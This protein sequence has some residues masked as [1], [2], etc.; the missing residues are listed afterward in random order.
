M[1]VVGIRVLPGNG[2]RLKSPVEV[3]KGLKPGWFPFGN[4]SEPVLTE[5]G[6]CLQYEPLS[7]GIYD[8]KEGRLHITISAIVGKNGSGK[9][10]LLDYL[11]MLINNAASK[12]LFDQYAPDEQSPDYARG[13]FAELYYETEG[14][15]K[16]LRCIDTEVTIHDGWQEIA[17]EQLQYFIRYQVA[18]SLFYLVV[19]NYG[20]YSLNANDYEAKSKLSRFTSK[21]NGDW[22]NSAFNLEQ[23]YIFPIAITPYRQGGIID[24]NMMRNES[25]EKMTALMMYTKVN[26]NQFIEGYQPERVT[27]TLKKGLGTELSGII[28]TIAKNKELALNELMFVKTAILNK[29]VERSGCGDLY[30]N[31][32]EKNDENPYKVFSLLLEYMATYT[33]RLCVYYEKFR[34]IFDVVKY[35]R[36]ITKGEKKIAE[37]EI[38]AVIGN[39][40]LTEIEYDRSNLTYGIRKC[41]RTVTE[42][43]ERGLSRHGFLIDGGSMPTA[44]FLLPNDGTLLDVQM[45][46]PP[47]LYQLDVIMKR[48]DDHPDNQR[49]S[50]ENRNGDE[51]R[52]SKLS[53]GEKQWLFSLTSALFHIKSLEETVG[54][55]KGISY[56]HVC[57]CFDEAEL[58]YHPEY[59]QNFVFNLLQYLSW[60]NLDRIRSIQVIIATHSPFI[61][62]DIQKD[63]ILYLRDGQDYR[64]VMTEEETVR[65]QQ[66]NTFGANYYDLLRNG[67]FLEDN[68]I[69]KFAATHIEN[70]R[71]QIMQGREDE[72]VQGELAMIADPLIRGYLQ[73]LLEQQHRQ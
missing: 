11:L 69:G 49:Y 16:R 51:I 52:F 30:Y 12:L 25:M 38:E 40:L 43:R 7:T 72:R 68:A 53:S 48:V 31:D 37:G 45:L 39:N 54:I 57:L 9:S 70:L 42:V 58:Y 3:M 61:L 29:W 14:S 28:E 2:K 18:S 33:L 5:N 21:V 17:P 20:L 56:D 63:N 73:Y 1:K 22:L 50:I 62:S 13:I 41:C 26:S 23:N 19:C 24:V 65:F 46:L 27:Y 60:L 44:D 47:P 32:P 34:R 35:T 15:V 4:Y 55:P 8:L 71:Q 64:Q 36:R 10:T 67:F 6:W 66:F 59:Q